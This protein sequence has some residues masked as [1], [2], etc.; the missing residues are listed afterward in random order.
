MNTRPGVA[1]SIVPLLSLMVLAGACSDNGQP[2]GDISVDLTVV[3]LPV[4]EDQARDTG[5]NKDGLADATQTGDQILDLPAQDLSAADQTVA[6][7]GS[8]AI[9]GCGKFTAVGCCDGQTLKLCFGNK[10]V[11]TDCAAAGKPKCGWNL[12]WGWYAC[13]TDGS[14]DP[15]GKAPRSCSAT[16]PDATMS[17]GSFT[18]EGCCDG[19]TLKYCENGQ[20]KVSDCTTSPKCGWDAAS[21]FYDCG[22][23]GYA[24]PS[25]KHALSCSG[26]S[27]DSGLLFDSAPPFDSGPLDASIKPD[28]GDACKGI[29]QDGC[30]A[31]EVL[32]FCNSSG[33]LVSTDCTA[34]KNPKCGWA[35]SYG[36]Y[37]CG[38]K[39]TADPLGKLPKACPGTAVDAGAPDKALLD[40]P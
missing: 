7:A 33:K 40:G 15:A 26:P 16:A 38:T 23:K 18:S 27:P 19:Q 4:I 2:E 8:D 6:D 20:V 17:C 13:G 32:K 36:W 14:S 12:K 35:A 25:G 9:Q 11:V 39:G 31:G 37:D 34:T 30:C 1:I 5:A 3:D 22:T 21:N 28:A 29:S 24:D 10:L